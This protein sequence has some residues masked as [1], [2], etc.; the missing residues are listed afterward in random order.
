MAAVAQNVN[1][2]VRFFS[3]VL[4]RPLTTTPNRILSQEAL[5]SAVTNSPCCHAARFARWVALSRQAGYIYDNQCCWRDP[6]VVGDTK[7]EI[8]QSDRHHSPRT[9]PRDKL[10]AAAGLRRHFRIC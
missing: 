6:R 3:D 5:P 4:R 2:T 10:L 8:I 9:C 1:R 7:Y